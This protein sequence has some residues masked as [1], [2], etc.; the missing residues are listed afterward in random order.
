MYLRDLLESEQRAF[1][2]EWNAKGLTKLLKLHKQ[3]LDITIGEYYND[4]EIFAKL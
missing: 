1:L 2:A 4:A 3:G